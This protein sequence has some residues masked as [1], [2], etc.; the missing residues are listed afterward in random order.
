MPTL[1][2]AGPRSRTFPARGLLVIQ[3]HDSLWRVTLEAGDVVGYVERF[4]T[5]AGGRYRAKR[6]LPRQRRFLVDGEF[7]EMGDALACFQ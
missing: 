1:D 5:P 4:E 2:F 3:L 6:F 7:W